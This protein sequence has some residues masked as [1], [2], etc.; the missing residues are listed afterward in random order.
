MGIG[1]LLLV[2]EADYNLL[3]R[4]LIIEMGINIEVVNEEIKIKLCP[5]RVEDEEKINSEVWYTPDSVGRLNIPPF[6]V[7]I[8]DPETPI[9]VKQ[10]PISPEGKNGLKPEI[11][12]LLSKGLLESCMSPFNTPILPIKRQM[13]HT[14]EK[15]RDYFAFEW[16]DP[17]THRRQQLRWTVLPQGFTESPNLFGQALE[18]ILQEYQTGEGVTLIQ[19]VDDLLIAGEAEDKVRAESIR[20]LNFLSAKGLKVSKAK[21][22]FVEEEVKYLGHY[23]RKGEKKIDP[24][25]VKGI[26]SI[27]PPKSKKQIRQLLGLMG[28]CRQWIENYSTKVKFLYEKLSQGGLVKWDEKDDKHLKALRHDLVNAP[29]LSLPDLKRPFYLFVNTDSGTAYGV[30]TQEWA[31]KKKP[32]GYLSKL[33][34]PVSR[35]W[36]TC[37]QALVACALLVEEASKIT[38]NGELR[39]LSPHNIRG[40]LQQKAE[41]WITDDRLLKYE[42]ILLDS[43]K[44]TLEVTALQNPA[45]FLYGRPSEDGLAHECLSTIEEETKIRPDLDEEELEEGDRLFVDG[46]S[47]VINGKR[48]S[49]YAIVGGEGLAVIESGP[50]S[51]SWSAQACELYAVLRALQLLKDKSGTIYTDSKYAYGI[52]HTFGKI[53]EERGL[54]NSQ[55][56]NLVHQDLIRKLLKALRGPR[57]IAVVHLKGHQ[58]G[59]DFKSRGNN[60]ADQEAR[61]AALQTSQFTPQKDP[62]AERKERETS[63]GNLQKIYSFTMQEKEKMKGMGLREDPEREW[64]LPK[65][66]RT[67]LPKSIAMDIM[68]RIHS[69]TH[70]GAQAL[71]DQFATKHMCIGA[72][73][74]AKQVPLQNRY[75]A[76]DLESQPDDLDDSEGNYLPSEPPKYDSSVRQISTSNIKKKRRAGSDEI[77][78][79]SIKAIKRDFRALGQVVDKTEAQVV[80]CSVPLVA[81]KNDERNRRTQIINKWLKGLKGEGDAAGLSGSRP[82]GGKPESGVK[83][84]AQLKCM[85]TNARSMGNK[86]KELEAMVQQQSYD[87]VAI[88]ETWWDDSHG[89]S[90]ALDGY[91]LFRRDR[92]G[93][94]GGGVALYI[95]KAFDA[96]GIET[97]EDGVEC[98]WVRIKGKA[99]KADILLGVCYHPP[100]QEEEVDNL[101]Y[102]QLENVSG[103]STLVLVGDFNLPDIIW[104]LDTAEKRQSRKFLECMED[105]F[106][107]QLVGCRYCFGLQ[108]VFSGKTTCLQDNCPLGLVDGASEQNSPPIIQEEAVRE[109]L[110]C[111]DTHKSMGPDGIHPRVMRELADELA[112][113]LCIIYHQ[114]W[115]TGEL[116]DDWKLA[117]VTPIHKKGGR[118]DP[119]SYRPVSQTSV[120][121]KIMEQF[122]LSLITQ[123]LQ[124]GQGLRP[125]QHGFRRGRSCLTHLISFY[126]QVTCLVDAGK[127]VDVV[128]LDFSKAFDTVSHSILLDKLAAR[129]LDRSTLCWVRNW[130]DGRVQR[131][132]VNDAASSWWPVASGVPRVCAGASSVQYFY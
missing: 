25:R 93:R 66:N 76:L 58:K 80:F 72:D 117:N 19:Y 90:T 7:I 61:R 109:L 77:E 85:Y 114:S 47:R 97:N 119:G 65:D 123:N 63:R 116:P 82:K 49:G 121:G 131:V 69:K 71:V 20:L 125:S 124:D 38:F 45:Q 52:I 79:R 89:W 108:D 44:L 78:K 51:G 110:R 91:K 88:M 115:L 36:P 75:E 27:P 126:D 112:K 132:V 99:N 103:S 105:N 23:L 31:G 50:L 15:S 98:L 35:G 83:S 10:Y 2:P 40:I 127:A 11:E 12:R 68:R 3:G 74:L 95:K 55:G 42:G 87:V 30:L 102:K 5:L 28:Y 8:K 57:K 9:R 34:D 17:V 32:V 122:I 16:E 84:V 100:N 104:E 81:E 64:R 60:A 21:L 67:V 62:E 120:P 70:W 129:V 1:N 54:I 59:L 4:D 53:W 46:S 73:D 128:Y 37:L 41:K 22:Q 48:V 43:P 18:Q 94:R 86:Q 24:E 96:I 111:L 6:S 26:L 92:K 101:F 113:P 39:V 56:K 29:V 33:L 13:N 118:E 130:L 14:D 107:S 106:L